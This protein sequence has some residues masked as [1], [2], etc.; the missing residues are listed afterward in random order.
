MVQS[1]TLPGRFHNLAALLA[2]PITVSILF[3]ETGQAA[4]R[5]KLGDP[6]NYGRLVQVRDWL[7]EHEE[8]G[9]NESEPPSDPA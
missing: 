2:F 1:E 5:L 4:W 9:P 8:G 3:L 7:A 6:D